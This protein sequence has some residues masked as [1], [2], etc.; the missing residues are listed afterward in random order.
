MN[1]ISDSFCFR[2]CHFSNLTPFILLPG[3]DGD[4]TLSSC[5]ELVSSTA[6]AV[7][8]LIMSLSKEGALARSPQ[9]PCTQS[10]MAAQDELHSALQSLLSSSHQQDT[11]ESRSSSASDKSAEDEI[12][13][14]RSATT[15]SAVKNL[16]ISKIT[17][18]LPCG[19][20]SSKHS[21][22]WV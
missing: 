13:T 17:Y 5:R 11:G 20:S 8:E 3:K 16:V 22:H 15:H 14:K 1:N 7:N 2:R 6:K 10:V 4:F 9:L 12:L 21:P 19:V 18:S